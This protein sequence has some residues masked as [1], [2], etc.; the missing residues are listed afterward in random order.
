M[1]LKSG[2]DRWKD[3]PQPL[4]WFLVLVGKLAQVRTMPGKGLSSSQRGLDRDWG[5]A[6]QNR[7]S[8]VGAGFVQDKARVR[9]GTKGRHY[10][11]AA[12]SDSNLTVAG[13]GLRRGVLETLGRAAGVPFRL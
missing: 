2:T 3:G 9:N 6:G 8:D 12:Q 11:T 10:Q 7:R 13:R 1:A 4:L 5:V